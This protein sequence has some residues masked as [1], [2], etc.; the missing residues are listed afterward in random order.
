MMGGARVCELRVGLK[1]NKFS[2]VSVSLARAQIFTIFNLV[3][4]TA[5]TS[6]DMNLSLAFAVTEAQWRRPVANEFIL[7]SIHRFS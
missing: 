6:I 5:D 3:V 1:R 4:S 2:S 7:F